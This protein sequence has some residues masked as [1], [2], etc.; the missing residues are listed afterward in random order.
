M[1]RYRDQQLQVGE[2]VLIFVSFDTKHLQILIFK[3]TFR[4]QLISW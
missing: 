4:S 3:H 2:I 1:P